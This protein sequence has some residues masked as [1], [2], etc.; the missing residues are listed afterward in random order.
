MR[1]LAAEARAARHLA[2]LDEATLEFNFDGVAGASFSTIAKRLGLTRAGIYNYCADRQDLVFQCYQRACAL[3]ED[4]LLRACD[5]PAS[6]AERLGVFLK[7]SVDLGHAPVSILSE[8]A[9]LNRKQ[10]VVIREARAKNVQFLKNL[11]L[12][13][14][15]D[16]SIRRCDLDV[17]CQAIFGVLSWAPLSRLWTRHDDAEFAARMAAA[18]PD[19]ILNGVVASNV[20]LPETHLRIVDALTDVQRTERERRLDSLARVGSM[21]FNRRG[22]DG[23]S[24]DDVALEMGATKGVLYHYFKSKSDFVACCYSRAFDIYERIMTVAESCSTGLEATMVAVELDVEAQLT[25][26]YPLWLQTGFRGLPAKMQARLLKR[27]QLLAARSVALA[28]RGVADGSLHRFDLEPVKLAAPGSF[29]Y[30]STWLP[31]ADERRAAQIAQEVSR[32]LLLGLRRR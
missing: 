30:L 3:V 18:I 31:P 15:Q 6:G 2:V 29:T 23:V 24:L 26:I 1:S 5:T 27:S 14:Q 28:K 8:L 20:Q 25:D 10:Q 13:G 11:L 7:I 17:V 19:M 4:D 16:G 21:L 12:E 9:F 32:F 22:I